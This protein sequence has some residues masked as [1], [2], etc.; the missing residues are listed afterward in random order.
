MEN[1]GGRRF[2]YYNVNKDSDE[3]HQSFSGIRGKG[4]LGDIPG[5]DFFADDSHIEIFSDKT[6]ITEGDPLNTAFGQLHFPFWKIASFTKESFELN[7][8]TYRV[9]GGLMNYKKDTAPWWWDSMIL[10]MSLRNTFYR[11]DMSGPKIA[12]FSLK[13]FAVDVTD[14]DQGM[15]KHA[16]EAR[17]CKVRN[18]GS[19][20]LITADNIR[21]YTTF[22][23]YGGDGRLHDYVDKCTLKNAWVGAKYYFTSF[24]IA[25]RFMYNL[26]STQNGF[27][28]GAKDLTCGHIKDSKGNDTGKYIM[29]FD[30]IRDIMVGTNRTA[31]L[32]SPRSYFLANPEG[33]FKDKDSGTV[34]NCEDIYG[35]NQFLVWAREWFDNDPQTNYNKHR[36]L[37]NAFNSRISTLANMNKK[38]ELY[39][40]LDIKS[41][42]Y[43]TMTSCWRDMN[44]FID[45]KYDEGIEQFFLAYL[46]VLYESRRYFINKRC[47]KQDG[48][49][50]ACRHLEKMIP[51][52]VASAVSSGAG[53]K[54]SEFNRTEGKETV[55]FYEV[56]NTIEMKTDALT[57][58]ANDESAM[59]DPDMIKTVYVKVK[60]A[61]E[62][63]YIRCQERLKSG[64]LSEND[65]T[66]IK[67]RPWNYIKKRDG[68][69]KN[70]EAGDTI[71]AARGEKWNTAGWA[72]KEGKEKYIIKPI[73]GPYG[74]L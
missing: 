49:L 69:Y 3:M 61:T 18:N 62:A 1:L 58:I 32:I 36:D 67:I 25:P 60:Y 56:Q 46:N 52:M 27:L 73:N 35:Y 22:Q 70:R 72:I 63:D 20:F 21:S 29:S 37:E 51:Q 57:K 34:Y 2:P 16:I 23:Q 14:L 42:S 40:D 9:E 26:V 33:K 55:A 74:I 59:L 31:P 53:V 39:K 24:D 6:R 48:T 38:L 15:G 68:S 17:Q 13:N 65:E 12:T 50:W 45:L 19:E 66:I 30:Y 11:G 71:N 8:N 28:N 64:E 47:N 54:P 10:N 44:A 5:L 43:N 7:G 41:M 4:I